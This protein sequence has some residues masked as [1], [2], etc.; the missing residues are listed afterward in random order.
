MRVTC[1]YIHGHQVVYPNEE[2][3]HK[4]IVNTV[5]Y[6][7]HLCDK[8]PD[9][10]NLKGNRFTFGSQ[11]REQSIKGGKGMAARVAFSMVTRAW[12]IIPSQSHQDKVYNSLVMGME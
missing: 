9:R 2:V 10:S 5:R 8:I 1:C 6:F 4:N 11:F 3:S 12:C 7:T